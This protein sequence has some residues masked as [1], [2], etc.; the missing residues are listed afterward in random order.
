MNALK[1]LCAEHISS[2]LV[3]GVELNS[4]DK[5]RTFF[6]H[7]HMV[8]P[9][10]GF[11]ERPWWKVVDYEGEPIVLGF[12][13]LDGVEGLNE[14]HRLEVADGLIARVRTCCFCPETLAVVAQALGCSALPRPYR[15]PSIVDFIMATRGL[16]RFPA[17]RRLP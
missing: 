10:L 13:A 5:A 16:R 14:I 15:S 2:E 6:E 1:A 11:G 4:F 12:R 8:M 9:K 7:A 17:P 3:G